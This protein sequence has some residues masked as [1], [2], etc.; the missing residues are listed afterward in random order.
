MYFLTGFTDEAADSIEDQIRV[1]QDLG[2]NHLELRT[3]DG[4]NLHDLSP[5]DF[6]RVRSA[7]EDSGLKVSCLGSNIANWGTPVETPLAETMKIVDRVIERAAALKTSYTRVMSYALR[8]DEKDK[9]LE[10]QKEKERFE[11]LRAICGRLLENGVTPVHENCFTYG[12][13]S[14]KHS[15]RLLEEVPGLKL[16]FDTGNPPLQVDYS[17]PEPRPMQSSWEFYTRVRPHIEYVHIKD[18]TFNPET[19]EELYR[20]PGEGEGEV[21]RI[22]QD[23]LE[24]GYQGGFSMEP[25]M[26]VV[27]HDASVTAEKST[28]LE[29]FSEYGRR[30]MRILS[31]TGFPYSRQE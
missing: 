15:L 2:W 4:V 19:K 20:F 14:W 3:V 27:Y 23:L 30:F 29:N 31:E 10:D 16:A 25:H 12:G 22:V 11:K 26:A 6:S 13:M 1:V 5:D 17:G 21:K 28:R 18:A 9:V 7:V 24:T 8:L